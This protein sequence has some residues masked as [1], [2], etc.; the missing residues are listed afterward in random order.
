MIKDKILSTSVIYVMDPT[1][2][3][4]ANVSAAKFISLMQEELGLSPKLPDVDMNKIRSFGISSESIDIVNLFDNIFKSDEPRIIFKDGKYRNNNDNDTLIKSVVM[5]S[6][7]IALEVN[8]STEEAERICKIVYN[9]FCTSGEFNFTWEKAQ[10]SVAL[11]SY[12]TKTESFLGANANALISAK[13][14]EAINNNLD[15]GIMLGPKMISRSKYDD[16]QPSSNVVSIWNLNQ[17]SIRFSIFNK[18]TGRTES[19]DIDIDVRAKDDIGRGVVVISSELSYED[20]IA[21]T[22]LLRENLN[23]ING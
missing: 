3:P 5:S 15:S 2:L 14:T 22:S 13:L 17:F 8:K 1:A 4:Y 23:K 19:S 11:K 12:R 6:E 16:F 7:H 10:D 18:T 21:F 9:L 20:H